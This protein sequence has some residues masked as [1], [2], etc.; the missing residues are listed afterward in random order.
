MATSTTPTAGNGVH[1]P[2]RHVI[3]PTLKSMSEL[4]YLVKV[5][6]RVNGENVGMETCRNDDMS[7]WKH[8][9]A[10]N[11]NCS[12]NYVTNTT[13]LLPLQLLLF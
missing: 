3:I 7:E 4:W 10:D 12:V 9:P 1:S 2:L 5:R 11:T 8:V 6:V 13:G